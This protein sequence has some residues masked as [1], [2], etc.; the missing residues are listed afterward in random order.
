M[1]ADR[2]YVEPGVKMAAARSAVD[3]G[4]TGASPTVRDVTC[5]QATADTLL[6]T[7]S[8]PDVSHPG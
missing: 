2:I 4:E 8:L 1:S 3:P 5:A 7:L 6:L